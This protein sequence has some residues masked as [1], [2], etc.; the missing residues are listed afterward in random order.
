MY[1]IPISCTRAT[2]PAKSANF[3]GVTSQSPQYAYPRE[4]SSVCQPSSTM[5]DSIPSGFA[6]RHCFSS[7]S[8]DSLW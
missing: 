3:D 8:G 6:S 1:F 4:L 2:C 5:T 7:P